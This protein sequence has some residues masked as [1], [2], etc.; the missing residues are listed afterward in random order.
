MAMA[1]TSQDGIRQRVP[2][3]SG[4][5]CAAVVA[6]L[7]QIEEE[8]SF[9]KLTAGQ[10]SSLEREFYVLQGKLS[11]FRSIAAGDSLE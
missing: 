7:K 5:E 6:R 1:T 9:P 3:L 4:H 8:L 2:R 11:R 10:S